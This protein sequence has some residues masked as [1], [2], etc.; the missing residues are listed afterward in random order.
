MNTLETIGATIRTARKN[1][2]KTIEDLSVETNVSIT[3]IQ[4]IERG[5]V[6]KL[7]TMQR[8]GKYFGIDIDVQIITL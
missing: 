5:E 2:N 6:V 3:S 7:D 8:Y 1:K 4:K